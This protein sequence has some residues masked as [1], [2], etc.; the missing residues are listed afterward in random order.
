MPARLREVGI[1]L[2][3]DGTLFGSAEHKRD[4]AHNCNLSLLGHERF[5]SYLRRLPTWDK[6]G[7]WSCDCK[8]TPQHIVFDYPKYRNDETISDERC[9]RAENAFSAHLDLG[10]TWNRRKWLRGDE[11]R[12]RLRMKAL[13]GMRVLGY[14]TIGGDEP[15]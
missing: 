8:Q 12:I 3:S 7:R 2:T 10:I 5:R 4:L 13:S 14:E 9:K 11:F 15:V 1:L 6:T